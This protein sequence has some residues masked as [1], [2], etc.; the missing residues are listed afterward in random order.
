MT[1]YPMLKTTNPNID[2]TFRIALGDIV[3]NIALWKDGLLK[4]EEPCIMAG[5]DYERPWTRDA[6][7]NTWNGVGLLFPQ[8]SRNTLLSTLIEE[9]GLVRIGGQYWD[10]IIWVL[11]AWSLYLYTADKEFLSLAFKAT[12]N[13][14]KYFEEREFNP[15]TGLFRGGACYADG[16]SAY[17]DIYAGDG[18]YSGILAFPKKNPHL[19]SGSGYGVPAQALSTNCLYYQ[20]YSLA[21]RMAEE[22]G[23][24]AKENWLLKGKKLKQSIN[25]SFWNEEKG[26][27][28]YLV[29]DFGNCEH[30]EGLGHSLAIL[31]GISHKTQTE[32]I[33]T[34]QYIT[35]W[36]IPCLWPSF[37]RYI[38]KGSSDVG[39]HSG[40]V[41][42]HIQGFW[43]HAAAIHRQRE[44]F[45]FELNQLAAMT[46][47]DGQFRELFHPDTGEP[48]PGIQEGKYVPL[49]CERQTWSATAYLRMVLMGLFG[50]KF[51]PKGIQFRPM[52]PSGFESIQINNLS[53]R[54]AL[55][56]ISIRGPGPEVK[57]FCLN[58]KEL[59]RAFLTSHSRGEQRIEIRMG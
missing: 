2:R 21:Y 26:M 56:H 28:R 3:T 49:C 27:Y 29:D 16:I 22:L 18:S 38:R 44:I 34:N 5:L 39:R 9:N 23:Q 59:D 12:E 10:A 51:E 40:T 48:Y 55:L 54:N 53:Y 31:F 58:G 14:L 35:R 36:G 11:G 42:P 17:P 24:P 1:F 13:S 4:K 50:M 20:A 52:L 46:C 43:A 37:P 15:K 30:E 41:W 33:F 25:T 57:S 8:V 32:K 19:A 6:A 7:I 47:R 45:T